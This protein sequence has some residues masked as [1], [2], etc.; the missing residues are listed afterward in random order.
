MNSGQSQSDKQGSSGS[1]EGEGSVRRRAEYVPGA[2]SGK[3]S[4]EEHMRYI[5]FIDGN[6]DKMRSR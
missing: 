2:C 4:A 1:Q 6:K 5:V 3:W